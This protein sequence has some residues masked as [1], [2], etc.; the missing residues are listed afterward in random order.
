MTLEK[1]VAGESA[2][3]NDDTV[4]AFTSL[5]AQHIQREEDELLPM[6]AR[7]LGVTE[8]DTIGQA[9]RERRGIKAV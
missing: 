1:V 2:L 4:T 9:M 7:L 3:L 8:L 6:A 5:Y